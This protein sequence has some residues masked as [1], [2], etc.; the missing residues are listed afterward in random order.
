MSAGGTLARL[1]RAGQ[2]RGC[3]VRAHLDLDEEENGA[4]MDILIEG[5]DDEP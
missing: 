4:M 5:S 2:W 1:L 3:A